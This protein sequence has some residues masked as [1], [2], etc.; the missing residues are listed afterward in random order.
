MEIEN[1]ILDYKDD[2]LFKFYCGRDGAEAMEFRKFIIE[3]VTGLKIDVSTTNNT[4]PTTLTIGDKKIIMDT[5]IMQNG[6]FD[7]YQSKRF[8]YYAYFNAD[9]PLMKK[10][11]EEK[12]KEFFHR[13]ELVESKKSGE[14][15]GFISR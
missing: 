7:A 1:A 4:E 6:S 15:E 3:N 10:L 14:K 12:E 11:L 9:I 13:M 2:L 8:Q 5:F